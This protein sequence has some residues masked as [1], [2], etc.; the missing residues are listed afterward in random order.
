MGIAFWIIITLGSVIIF[1][2][3]LPD[4]LDSLIHAR[5]KWRELMK[6]DGE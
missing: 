6:K 2:F 4:L 1:A 3:L 5:E